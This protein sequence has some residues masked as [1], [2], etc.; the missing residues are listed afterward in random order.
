LLDS[1]ETARSGTRQPITL[2]QRPKHLDERAD[3]E[4][5]DDPQQP[6]N[7]TISMLDEG[8]MASLYT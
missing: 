5:L 4:R 6:G 3:R 2:G 8:A 1:G 7:R